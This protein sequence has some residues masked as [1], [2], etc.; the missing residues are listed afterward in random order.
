M[1]LKK[2]KYDFKWIY[3]VPEIIGKSENYYLGR[4]KML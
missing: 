2:E 4:V 1:T 3:N